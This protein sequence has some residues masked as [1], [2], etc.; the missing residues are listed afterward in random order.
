MFF[1]S[2]RWQ[3]SSAVR[4]LLLP[5]ILSTIGHSAFE[6]LNKSKVFKSQ[7]FE[8]SNDIHLYCDYVLPYGLV[9]LDQLELSVDF[10]WLTNQ[11]QIRF[12]NSGDQLY[13]ERQF[14]LGWIGSRDHSV[15]QLRMSCFQLDIKNYGSAKSYALDLGLGYQLQE[16]LYVGLET[17][18]LIVTGNEVLSNALIPE[19]QLSGIFQNGGRQLLRYHLGQS[20]D[21]GLTQTIMYELEIFSGIYLVGGFQTKPQEILGSISLTRHHICTRVGFGY[22]NQLGLTSYVGIGFAW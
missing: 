11:I 5:L 14:S 7:M 21:F 17:F 22:Q 12:Y 2:F 1:P 20:A 4:F 16:S 9:F 18:N 8:G 6:N 10:P 13:C 19:F 3:D 15:G